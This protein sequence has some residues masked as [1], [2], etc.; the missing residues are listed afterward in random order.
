MKIMIF[1]VT[2]FNLSPLSFADEVTNTD[3]TE[4]PYENPIR[5]YQR[6]LNKKH[7]NVLAEIERYRQQLQNA[8]EDERPQIVAGFINS[9]ND[10]NH[11]KTDC[12][13]V[14][15]AAYYIGLSLVYTYPSKLNH[16]DRKYFDSLV[17]PVTNCYQ[18][19][20]RN[21]KIWDEIKSLTTE[22]EVAAAEKM[23]A[24]DQL[25]L[26]QKE[27]CEKN[28]D[29]YDCIRNTAFLNDYEK[30]RQLSTSQK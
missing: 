21:N 15:M 26:N 11:S 18:A 12:N 25:R 19:F 29:S 4:V 6:D 3:V 22:D 5:W 1:L 9:A 23:L 28:R 16:R 10:L 30:R 2:I 20:E 14:V 17:I 8:S 27:S 13:P 7:E 24:L